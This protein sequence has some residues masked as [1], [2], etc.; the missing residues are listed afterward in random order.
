MKRRFTSAIA[1]LILLSTPGLA[2]FGVGDIVHDPIS[3]ANALVILAQLVESYEQLKAQLELEI[4]MAKQLPVD[5]LTRYRVPG[6]SWS[7]F[8]VP[9]DRFGNLGAWMDA[10]NAA[11]SAPYG[12]NAASIGLLPYGDG[13]TRLTPSEQE[14][15]SSHYASAELV[16]GANLHG[17]E[18]LGQLQANA[19]TADEAIRMLEWDSLSK[20]P[21][22]N[23]QVGVLNKI[24]A[25]SVAALRTSRDTNRALSSLLEQGVID[26]KA[27]RDAQ[28]S[29]INAQI[30]RL[31]YG[32][33]ASAERVS[34]ITQSVSS[35]RWRW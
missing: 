21:A 9:H 20:D 3:Y 10:V 16:D 1:V 35:F 30:M 5:M 25:A 13:F 7:S 34:T 12:Y 4:R 24:N 31:E 33:E 6:A 22:M 32:R 19:T 8:T 23:T 18:A 27:R 11:G 17:I 14:K 15:V 29:E 26:S 28:V 2:L